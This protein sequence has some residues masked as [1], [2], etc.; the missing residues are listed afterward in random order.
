MFDGRNLTSANDAQLRRVR[1]QVVAS[2]VLIARS[3]TARED[4]QRGTKRSAGPENAWG[5]S[6]QSQPAFQ[7]ITTL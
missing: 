1:A 4:E 6:Q 5:T 7:L 3:R 2:A